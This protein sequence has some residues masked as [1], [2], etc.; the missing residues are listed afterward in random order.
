MKIPLNK[1]GIELI[2]KRCETRVAGL[3]Q[4][5][6]W[7]AARYLLD[8]GYHAFLGSGPN[9]TNGPGWS[10]YYA[11]NWNCSVGSIDRSVIMPERDPFDEKSGAYAG[12]LGTKQDD[13]RRNPFTDAKVGDVLYVT[14]SVYYGKWLNEGGT[15]FLT[16]QNDSK[17][18]RFMELCEAYLR[19]KMSD[20]IRYVKEEK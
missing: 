9:S 2:K 13:L 6:A 14:N 3:L 5:M 15:E 16:H 20:F 7:E 17:P 1:K 12:D 18:N 11:A 19:D 4:I 10:Y 8:F